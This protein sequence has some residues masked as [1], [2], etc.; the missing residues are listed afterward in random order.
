MKTIAVIAYDNSSVQV[1]VDQVKYFMGDRARILQYSV[2]ED[3]VTRI[4]PADLYLIS[5]CAYTELNNIR[6]YLPLK[7]EVVMIRVTIRRDSLNQLLKVPPRTKALLVNI[8]HKMAIETMALLNQLGVDNIEFYPCSPNEEYTPNIKFAVTPGE[9]RYVPKGIAEVLDIGP[10]V[11]SSDTVVEMML[12]L[13]SE[14]LMEEDRLKEYFQELVDDNYSFNHMFQRS[15]Q[16]EGLFDILQSTLNIGIICMDGDSV[17]F[18]FNKKAGEILNLSKQ[19][20]LDKKACDILPFIPFEECLTTRREIKERM[21]KV[22]NVDI[23]LSIVPVVRGYD[24]VGAMATIQRFS[25]EEYRQHKLRCQ[26]MNK[27]HVA[28]YTFDSIAGSSPAIGRAK[29]VAA[30][31]AKRPAP[32]LLTGESGTGKELFAHAIH[33]ASDRSEYPFVAINCAAIPDNLMESE[34]FGYEEG[35]FTGAKKGGKMG[36]FEFAHRGTLFLDEIEGMSTSLQ[37]KLLRVIQE[38]EV[39]RVGGS[40]IINVN[41]RIIAATN[42]NLEVLVQRGEFRKDLYYRLNVLS[43][44]LPPLRERGGDVLQLIQRFKQETDSTFVLTSETEKILLAQTWDGNIRQ[45]RNCV[46]YLAC[47]DKQEICP[48]DLPSSLYAKRDRDTNSVSASIKASYPQNTPSYST[49]SKSQRSSVR[50]FQE[51]AHLT[52]FLL[53]EM[54][55]RAREGKSC[56]RRYLIQTIRDSGYLITE[57][58]LREQIKV[59]E[60]K[61]L[62]RVRQGRGGSKITSNGVK[63][64][65]K[66]HKKK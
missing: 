8:S 52:E 66:R 64:L 35:A 11:L 48:E 23:T 12:K 36:Y 10:R 17:V 58:E 27:G 61:E 38:K 32:V 43:I 31:M 1:Y 14:E 41:V 16:M 60:A 6:K 65:N 2:K 7:G 15:V 54:E 44:E 9:S 55:S 22:Q 20:V 53:N 37:L 24:F 29:E 26:L 28:K 49:D 30:K 3:L 47:L 5:T 63:W 40:R 19:R 39:L 4:I 62:I 33:A 42:E 59:M 45:L 50:F 21:L 46:E 25:D 18:F 51:D 13:H 56:G 57:R 34:L